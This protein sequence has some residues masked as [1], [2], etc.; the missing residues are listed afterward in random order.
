M[1]AFRTLGTR[2]MVVHM[3]LVH[4]VGVRLPGPEPIHYL[5]NQLL[6]NIPKPSNQQLSEDQ[7]ALTG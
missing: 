3:I 1:Y 7:P 5:S 4:G 2:I 6:L